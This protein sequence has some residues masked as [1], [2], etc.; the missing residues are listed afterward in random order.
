MRVWPDSTVIMPIG[1]EMGTHRS[2]RH[3]ES[4]PGG[5]AS[6]QQGVLIG[7]ALVCGGITALLGILGLLGWLTSLRTLASVRSNYIPMAP[8]TAVNFILFGAVVILK[9]NRA[10]RPPVRRTLTVLVSIAMAYSLLKLVEYFV[11]LDRTFEDAVFP[12][13]GKLGSFPLG[14][15]S[16]VTGSLFFLSGLGSLVPLWRRTDRAG[17]NLS[18]ILGSLVVTMGFVATVG[19]LFATPL[20]YGSSIIPLAATTALGFLFLGAGLV[21]TAPDSVLSRLFFSA[22]LRARL[23]RAFFPLTATAILI[24]GLSQD[25][26]S[27]KFGASVALL[28]AVLTLVFIAFTAWVVYWVARTISRSI[29]RIDAA[30][31]DS[32]V[33]YRRLFE[34]AQ[35]GIMILDAESGV[36]HDVNP[37]LMNLLGMSREEVLGKPIWEV[38]QLKDLVASSADLAELQ[39][40][41]HVRHDHLLE[42]A[43]GSEVD[44]E[45]VSTAYRVGGSRLVQCNF[46]DI[47]ARKRA[48]R[49]QQD[50]QRKFSDLFNLMSDGVQ[51]CELVFDHEGR[52]VDFVVLDANAAYEK[53]T[54]I[55]PK[56]ALGRGV[57][58]VL[59]VVEP[60]WLERYGQL[61]RDGRPMDFEEYSAGL[62]RWYHISASRTHGNAF[63]VIFRDISEHKRDEEELRKKSAVVEQSSS[64]VI[65]ANLEGNIEYVNPRFSDVTGY[66]LEEV[67]GK[68]PRLL[69]S[70]ETSAEEYRRLWATISAGGIW[71][72]EFHNR[73]KDGTLYWE[74]ASISTLRDSAGKI[75]SYIGIKEDIT[76]RKSLEAQFIQAQKMESVGRLAGGVAHDFNNMLQVISS[77]ADIAMMKTESSHAIYKYLSQIREAAGRSADLTRQLLAFAR[78]QTITPKVVDLNDAVSKM[79]KLLQR[80]IGDDIEI[81]W[82]PSPVSW[83]VRID[84]SQVDQ[85]LANLS[86]NSR[87]AISQNGRLTIE[88]ENTVLDEAYCAVHMGTRP[89][90][91]VMLAVS[92]N[93]SGMDK[94]T[95]SHVFEPF[96][97]TKSPGRG[98]GLGT[99]TVFG[100]VKQNEGFV[101][102]YSEP[103]VGTTFRIYLPRFEA[104]GK[105]PPSRSE[106]PELPRGTETVL[107]VEDEAGILELSRELL[108]QLGYVVLTAS[109]PKEAIRLIAEQGKEVDLLISDVVMPEMNGR[110]LVQRISAMR[111]GL[112]YIFMS[113]YTADVISNQGVLDEGVSFIQKP[114]SVQQLATKVREALTR[115]SER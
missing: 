100:I 37:Y 29:S 110:E 39:Q 43:D 11:H 47:S 31:H 42:A 22:S 28:S 56:M 36:I 102:V 93:G 88:T 75:T 61:I 50:A 78:K 16:P 44:I 27:R 46:R 30:A 109:G 14:R 45:I 74:H 76:P 1:G 67:R 52:P 69:K 71:D 85:I 6:T 111:A 95:L 18:S 81:L 8:N 55:P 84:P 68:N 82:K 24:Q 108:A 86:V 40:K 41:E 94:E 32:E 70:G 38:R 101:S 65:I 77:Y 106:P 66:S 51:F 57:T 114:F 90:E 13:T 3:G 97:T 64:L 89:G 63:F 83:F 92:D 104:G 25:V 115:T 9:A 91:Y 103:G 10:M 23:M 33:R 35:D 49:Q 62:K 96:F 113:G 112:K 4:T 72:G 26:L 20:L 79:L 80:L 107:V 54:G 53:Q 105:T 34:A 99:A 98:T 60:I 12:I 59:P 17:Q 21:A 19:Y 7:V 5:S 58:Q 2:P 15:M 73:K 48:E 87:D